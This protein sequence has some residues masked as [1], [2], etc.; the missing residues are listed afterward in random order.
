MEK[1]GLDTPFF[2]MS[3]VMCMY[4]ICPGHVFYLEWW[5]RRIGMINVERESRGERGRAV[6]VSGEKIL[7]I[8]WTSI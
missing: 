1:A 3:Y 8:S 2:F 7:R 5:R 6:K 4:I